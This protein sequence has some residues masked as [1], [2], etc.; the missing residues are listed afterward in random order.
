MNILVGEGESLFCLIFN[1]TLF[2]TVSLG[3][4]ASRHQG[5]ETS[6]TSLFGSDTRNADET[7]GKGDKT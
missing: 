5:K 2:L 4:S 3:S 7:L 1:S 6:A